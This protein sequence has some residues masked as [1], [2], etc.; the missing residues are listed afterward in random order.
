MLAENIGTN[1]RI[2]DQI[3]I[4]GVHVTKKSKAVTVEEMLAKL[5][6]N[7]KYELEAYAITV[8]GEVA[9][10]LKNEAEAK[11]VLEYLNTQYIPEGVEGA[12]VTYVQDVKIVSDFIETNQLMSVDAAKQKMAHG[13]GSPKTCVIEEGQSL[14]SIATRYNMSMNELL[15]LNPDLSVTS[16]IYVGENI[17]VKNNEP[18]ITVRAAVT[19][20]ETETAEKEIEYQ[21]DN[22]KNKSYKKIIQQ[23]KAGVTE[24]KKEK[25]YING[26]FDSENVVSSRV[27][28]QPVKEIVCVGT[29]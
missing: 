29:N 4:K 14:Y 12:T 5:K 2:L 1:T 13:D 25:V 28:T 24:V 23:G 22:T 10:A 20:T 19:T 16:K 6:N 7:V 15:S 11:E 8:D 3:D 17:T 21:Y 9:A 18:V 27:I 26:H